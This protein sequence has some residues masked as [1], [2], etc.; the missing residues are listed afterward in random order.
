M[1]LVTQQE[2]AGCGIAVVASVLNITYKSA[3]KL[4]DNP[5]YCYLRGYYCPELVRAL[6]KANKCYVFAKVTKKNKCLLDRVGSIVFVRDVHDP[7]D[8]G[9]YLVRT[10]N[11]WMDSWINFPSIIPA[12]SGFR[13]TLAV[14]VSAQW[15]IYKSEEKTGP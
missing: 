5:E 12:K 3:K 9:H 7:Q 6:S 8:H 10:K 13:K 14:S 15:I 2:P 4:F 11:G 1:K